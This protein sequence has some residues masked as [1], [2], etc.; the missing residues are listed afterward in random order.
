MSITSNRSIKANFHFTGLLCT[1]HNWLISHGH[2]GRLF[3]DNIF[4]CN[5]MNENSVFW[6]KFPWSLILNR[7]Q[8]IIWT[9]VDLIHWCIYM[10]LVGDE[11]TRSFK[12]LFFRISLNCGGQEIPVHMATWILINTASGSDF[13][14]TF[15]VPLKTFKDFCTV[16]CLYDVVKY[17]MILDNSAVAEVEFK[18]EYEP[19]RD[20]PYLTLT[21]ELWGA[22]CEYFGENWP[23]YNGTTVI[24]TC[25]M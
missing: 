15:W 1:S 19:T 5:Y 14:L 9:N 10:A 7:W 21:G 13:F 11:L 18:S 6:L 12:D 17:N 24:C 2:N 4:R 23:R 8:A 3:A 22:L 16:R 25:C 20:S